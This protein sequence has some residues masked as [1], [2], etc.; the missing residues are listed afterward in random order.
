MTPNNIVNMSLLNE[1][2]VIAVSDHNSALNVAVTKSIGEKN[3]ILVVPAIEVCSSEE[4]HLLCLFEE[5]SAAESFSEMLY[6][7]LPNVINKPDIFGLQQQM[8]EEDCVISEVS[9]LL[10]NAVDLSIDDLVS[11]IDDYSGL[12]IPAHIDKN[13]YSIISNLGFIPPDYH[14]SCVEIKNPPY[15]CDF[16]GN[17]ITN[18]DAHYL[19]D[20]NEKQHWIETEEKSVKAV[21][22]ALRK[23]QEPIN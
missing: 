2:D 11:C 1:L 16:R 7:H 19:Y 9:K 8:D 23:Y 21:I 17:I 13:S 6:E 10:I 20:I 14:F 4:V 12:I 3:R 15:E 5:I 22:S 18:S